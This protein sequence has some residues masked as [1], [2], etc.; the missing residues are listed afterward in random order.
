[1]I[2]NHSQGTVGNGDRDPE[3]KTKQNNK[4]LS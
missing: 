4:D 3:M 1:M 2:Y